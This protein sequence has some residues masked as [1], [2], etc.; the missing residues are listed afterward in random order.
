VLLQ[1]E[2]VKAVGRRR[3]QLTAACHAAGRDG[4]VRLRQKRYVKVLEMQ[5]KRKYA[6][7]ARGESGWRGR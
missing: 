7:V 1:P 3:A 2:A 6:E 4:N 5:V